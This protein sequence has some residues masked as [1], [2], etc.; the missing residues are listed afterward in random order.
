MSKDD[1][2]TMVE[3]PDNPFDGLTRLFHEPK[4]LAIVSVLCARA[5]VVIFTD[6]RQE[7]ETT[8]GNLSR[9]LRTLEEAGVIRISKTFVGLKPQTSVELTPGGR[10]RFM[11]Y[12]QSL[13]E[14]LKRAENALS[15]GPSV[16][17]IGLADAMRAS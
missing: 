1:E 12:L 17:G 6:L 14:V 9:H 16:A 4:R 11:A 2:C 7:C 3:Q 5:E 13:E 10:K 8:D 15:A